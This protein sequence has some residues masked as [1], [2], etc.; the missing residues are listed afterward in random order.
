MDAGQRTVEMVELTPRRYITVKRKASDEPCIN[1]K[2]FKFVGTCQSA[3]E[4]DVK[5]F[6]IDKHPSDKEI[7]L[8][9]EAFDEFILKEKSKSFPKHKETVICNGLPLIPSTEQVDDDEE[10]DS[11]GYM[12]DVYLYDPQEDEELVVETDYR[13]PEED[14]YSSNDEDHPYNEYPD[15]DENHYQNTDFY[16]DW[17]DDDCRDMMKDFEK[18]C[19]KPDSDAE[20]DEFGADY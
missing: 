9:I 7:Q 13:D 18:H 17:E 2:R 20:S 15:E 11:K 6:V 14:E 8:R 16:R 12:F 19:L 4:A 3:N 5:Q 1:Q 10:D